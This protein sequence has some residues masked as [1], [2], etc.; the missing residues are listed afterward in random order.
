MTSDSSAAKMMGIEHNITVV[1]K[2]Q[3]SQQYNVSTYVAYEGPLFEQRQ[4]SVIG[5]M[6]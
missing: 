4:S 1:L 5:V 6:F 3:Q 2:Q